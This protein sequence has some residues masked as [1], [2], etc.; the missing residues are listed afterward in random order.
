MTTMAEASPT[1]RLA[2]IAAMCAVV[3]GAT[4]VAQA[5]RAMLLPVGG[6]R[7][8]VASHGT[9]AATR[10][11]LDLEEAGIEVLAGAELAQA[12]TAAHAEACED[13]SCA[14]PSL[15]PLG[16]QFAVGVALW[17]YEDGVQVEVGLIDA[18]GAVFR[19][20]EHGAANTVGNLTREALSAAR[21]SFGQP[22]VAVRVE[23]TAGASIIVDR[24][25]WGTVPFEGRLAPGT[26][27]FAVSLHGHVT[28][29]R[30]VR[31]GEATTLTFE[32]ATDAGVS[33]PGP[34]GGPDVGLIVAGGVLAAVGIGV[35]VT[36]LAMATASESCAR[37]CT[38][39]SA[40]RI[41][42]VPN[43]EAGIGLAVGGAVALAVGVVLVA[44]GASAGS[45]SGAVSLG[46]EG[47]GLRF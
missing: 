17:T 16:A 45:G 28:E 37:G 21:R 4:S 6:D 35:G 22:P 43:V 31:I 42:N 24:A 15:S 23:G 25:P 18:D 40:D 12:L 5:Q 36:G 2:W 26:H 33:A 41:V 32:L 3:L 10:V 29:R 1:A 27:Q 11:Q 13:A 47:V 20:T 46:P 39:P 34:G 9:E 7:A 8:L 19:A 38:G 44:V 30:D 14:S